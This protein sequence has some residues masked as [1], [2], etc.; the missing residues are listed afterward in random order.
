MNIDLL[1][2]ETL[3]GQIRNL[4][5]R[6]MG[7]GLEGMGMEVRLFWVYILIVFIYDPYKCFIYLKKKQEGCK[8]KNRVKQTNQTVYQTDKITTQR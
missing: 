8:I 3:Q 4:S 2:E 6:C 1:H 5:G 7:N